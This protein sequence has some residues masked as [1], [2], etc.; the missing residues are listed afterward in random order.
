MK[1]NIAKTLVRKEFWE[2]K[3]SLLWVPA[4]LSALLIVL[5]IWAVVKTAFVIGESPTISLSDMQF[6][7]AEFN[8]EFS[9]ISPE[10]REMGARMGLTGIRAPF[11]FVLLLVTFFYFLSCM[12]DER[13]DR[14]IYFWRSMP[15]SDWQSTLTKVFTGVVAYP[16]VILASAAAVH[17]I[18]MAVA[19][20]A[21]WTLEISAWET[22]WIPASLPAFWFQSLIGY[23][24][25]MLWAAPLIMFLL[26]LGAATK[27]PLLFALLFPLLLMLVEKL[28]FDSH[29]F[30]SWLGNR[31]EGIGV[32]LWTD[33]SHMAQSEPMWPNVGYSQGA[34]LLGNG[35]FWV[36]LVLAGI[37]LSG[38]V[39]ARKR[40]QEV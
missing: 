11:D 39:Y 27:R 37:L 16:V 17:V 9:K 8:Q 20:I 15:V 6:D 3:G 12:H 24:A 14:S 28:L 29:H 30:G 7:M 10:K 23:W 26:L 5:F 13:K 38:A 36:G 18:V 19:T 40:L 4:G 21:A 31:F 35:Q 34:E 2:H 25:M 1:M 32:L 33:M 22:L